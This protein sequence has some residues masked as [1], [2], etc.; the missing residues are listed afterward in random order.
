MAARGTSPREGSNAAN[1]LEDRRKKL[2]RFVIGLGL[3]SLFADFTYEGGRSIVGSYLA[4]IGAS[5]IIARC[6]CRIRRTD[7]VRDTTPVGP[8]FRQD[9][10]LLAVDECRIR[11]ESAVLTLSLP[12]IDPVPDNGAC[13]LG[14]IRQGAP[15]SSARHVAVSGR[16]PFGIRSRIRLA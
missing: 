15:E 2:F 6:G 5:P 3:V 1:S 7:R 16:T 4:V 13:F 10:T 9:Q 8:L 14:T 11:P 12:G